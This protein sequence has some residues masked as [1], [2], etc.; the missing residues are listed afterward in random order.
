MKRGAPRGLPAAGDGTAGVGC[1]ALLCAAWLCAAL[2]GCAS[3]PPALDTA[4]PAEMAALQP[5]PPPPPTQSSYEQQQRDRALA[6]ARQ[7]RLADAAIAW[8][9]LT[10]LRPEAADY[11]E[12]L[13]D[14]QRQIEAAV[15]ERAPRAAQ[16]A[17]RGEIDN[18]TQLYLAILALQP[19]NAPA[20]EALRGLE[21]ERN[22]RNYLGKSSRS[23]LTRRAMAE[24]EMPAHVSSDSGGLAGRNEVEH[25]ALLADDGEFDDAIGLL[26]RRLVFDPKDSAARRLLADVYYRKAESLLPRNRPGAI[27]AL[28]KS[29]RIYPAEPRAASRLNQLNSA[30]GVPKTTP[31]ARAASAGSA[32]ARP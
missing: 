10:V 27:A 21:R 17:Q 2:F 29:A 19:L 3:A 11:R 28:E 16:A 6:F 23:T 14:T 13:A 15:A 12:R 1:V 32:T 26:E 7:K 5:A 8:E 31:A 30:A 4:V 22:K 24:A 18:A 20:A 25:A 9:L